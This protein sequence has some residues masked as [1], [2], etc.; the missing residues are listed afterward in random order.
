[1]VKLEGIS[2]DDFGL[3]ISARSR[4]ARSVLPTAVGPAS[5]MYLNLPIECK[6][7][8]LYE[9]TR[10]SGAAKTLIRSGCP[11]HI[12]SFGAAHDQLAAEKLFIVKFLNSASSFLDGCHLNEGKAFGTLCILVTDDLGILNLAYPVK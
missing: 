3:Q 8:A 10:V 9:R 6:R 12:W 7:P 11:L 1:M 2:A 5:T 4:M